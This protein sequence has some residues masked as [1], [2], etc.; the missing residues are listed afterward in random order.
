MVGQRGPGRQPSADAV[1]AAA[2]MRGGTARIQSRHRC[3]R[4]S[5]TRHRAEHQLLVQLR[6]AAVDR[7][8]PEIG[9]LALQVTG[10]LHGSLQHPGSESRREAFQHLLDPLGEQ[11]RRRVVGNSS[12]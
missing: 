11:V 1:H 5:E 12:G 7:A 2:G 10:A 6:G 8:V 3:L 9:V 4:S